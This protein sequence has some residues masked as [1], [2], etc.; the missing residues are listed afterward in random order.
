MVLRNQLNECIIIFQ[1]Q[2]EKYIIVLNKFSDQTSF[3]IFRT[4]H[5]TSVRCDG[6]FFFFF[7]HRLTQYI[8]GIERILRRI[9]LEFSGKFHQAFVIDHNI[10]IKSTGNLK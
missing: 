2:V 5:T 9:K 3:V 6:H 1:I 8:Q 7:S 10:V 4:Q